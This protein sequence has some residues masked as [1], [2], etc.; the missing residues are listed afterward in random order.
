MADATTRRQA[1]HQRLDAGNAQECHARVGVKT[2]V[3]DNCALLSAEFLVEETIP[4]HALEELTHPTRSVWGRGWGAVEGQARPWHAQSVCVA[5]M[6]HALCCTI[7]LLPSN[8]QPIRRRRLG[9]SSLRT[10]SLVSLFMYWG[11]RSLPFRMFLKMSIG[12][13]PMKGGWPT[14]ISYMMIPSAHQSTPVP[15]PVRSTISGAMYSAVPQK[16]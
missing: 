12:S 9:R 15:C 6:P 13:L 10:R 1:N 5:W 4:I 16:V 8:E 2:N 3:G 11:K 7:F 14:N